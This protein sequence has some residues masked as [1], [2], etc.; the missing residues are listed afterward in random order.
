MIYYLFLHLRHEK[1][2]HKLLQLSND[3]EHKDNDCFK[4]I[5]SDLRI[6]KIVRKLRACRWNFGQV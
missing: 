1:A 4:V 3:D 5:V 6:E 2:Q